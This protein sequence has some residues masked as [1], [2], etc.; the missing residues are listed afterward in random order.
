LG[1]SRYDRSQEEYDAII[2][3]L[4]P[5]CFTLASTSVFKRSLTRA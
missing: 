5:K 3:K 1:E 4:Q 2:A